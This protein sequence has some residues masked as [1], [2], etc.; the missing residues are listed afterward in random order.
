[1]AIGATGTALSP[2]LSSGLGNIA[3]AIGTPNASGGGVAASPN[4]LGAPRPVAAPANPMMNTMGNIGSA[5]Q[6]APPV[7]PQQPPQP[8][9]HPNFSQLSPHVTQ[10]LKNLPPGALQQLHNMGMIHPG[11]MQHL[12][13]S[14]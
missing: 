5:V 8:Q 6:G 12:N 3:T 2:T 4:G 1:M 13:G 7:Q 9:A 11:L 10:A 14:T